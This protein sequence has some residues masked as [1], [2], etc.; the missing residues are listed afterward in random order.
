MLSLDRLKLIELSVTAEV[1]AS[2][3]T[4]S[5][6]PSSAVTHSSGSQALPGESSGA[7]EHLRSDTGVYTEPLR[8]GFRGQPEAVPAC[9]RPAIESSEET[10]SPGLPVAG[11]EKCELRLCA[12][13]G[14]GPAAVVV[15]VGDLLRVPCSTA[16]Q[17]A[18]PPPYQ[19]LPLTFVA[20]EALLAFDVIEVSNRFVAARRRAR[21][22]A[23]AV[24]RANAASQLR[25]SAR[26]TTSSEAAWDLP[27]D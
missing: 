4:P 8:A 25:S 13:A 22:A 15:A 3:L 24:C 20:A 21:A 5:L 7:R 17:V 26:K 14:T 1:D 10:A 9:R 23:E 16:K 6:M 12:A 19:P 11:F 2:T 27:G 18:T